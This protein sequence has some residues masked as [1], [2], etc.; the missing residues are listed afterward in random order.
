[1]PC[2]SQ[3]RTPQYARPIVGSNNECRT[4]RA[5]RICLAEGCTTVLSIYNPSPLCSLHEGRRNPALL[6]SKRLPWS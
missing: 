4:Y 2:V 1:V 3:S 5:G 6:R